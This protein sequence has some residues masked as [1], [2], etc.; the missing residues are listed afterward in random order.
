MKNIVLTITGVVGSALSILFGG[1]DSILLTLF[2]CM[3]I[4][5][6]TGFCVA[7][8]FKK[9]P[10]TES[11]ALESRAGYK[12]LVRKGMVLLVVLISNRL[13][14]VM[15]TNFIKDGVIVAYIV[16]DMVSIVENV[17]LMGVPMPKQII[18]A[19]DIL[20]EKNDEQDNF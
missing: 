5:Y 2:I 11:G 7:A 8:V 9:S 1:L 4:D 17:G 10:K 14:I 20:K 13:D 15:G 18:K 12:G 19:I 3:A 6:I 16:N